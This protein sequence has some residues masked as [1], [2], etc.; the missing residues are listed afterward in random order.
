ML[1]AALPTMCALAQTS[2]WLHTTNNGA[3]TITRY[4]GQDAAVTVPDTINGLP[5]TRLGSLGSP[6]VFASSG[7]RVESLT[8]P[9]VPP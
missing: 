9:V 5:V 2:P 8:I 6:P 1:L 4:T 3:I 7:F